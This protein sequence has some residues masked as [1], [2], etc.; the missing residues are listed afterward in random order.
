MEG[1]AELLRPTI[2]ARLD[3]GRFR[4]LWD[5]RHVVYAAF[6][7]GVFGGPTAGGLLVGFNFARMRRTVLA[8]A[9]ALVGLGLEIGVQ[10]LMFGVFRAASARN[11]TA[12]VSPYRTGVAIAAMILWLGAAKLQSPAFVAVSLRGAKP[13]TLWP[14]ALAAAALGYG[15]KV[16][17]NVVWERILL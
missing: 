6:F 1:D 9:S 7:A 3:A 16:G 5:P 4:P 17:V 13:P 10:Y 2:D 12:D 11:E 15:A 8:V 14:A